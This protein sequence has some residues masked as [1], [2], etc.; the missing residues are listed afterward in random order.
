MKG[1]V[2]REK[3]QHELKGF[4]FRIPIC[5]IQRKI[6]QIIFSW[7]VYDENRALYALSYPQFLIQYTH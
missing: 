4:F 1:K 6:F 7:Q 3:L 2:I 5:Q